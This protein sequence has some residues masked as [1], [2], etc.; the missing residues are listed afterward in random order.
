M[1]E[2]NYLVRIRLF[3]ASDLKPIQATGSADTFAVV[4]ALGIRQKTAVKKMTTSPLYDKS[5]NFEFPNMD[6][7]KLENAKIKIEVWEY[8]RFLPNELLGS[9]EIDLTSVYY[10]PYHQFYRVGFH[11]SFSLFN[12][13]SLV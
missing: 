6:K 1:K 3:E 12:L 13:W 10:K 8:Y 11:S 4:E 5:F 2:G 9:Y 7:H